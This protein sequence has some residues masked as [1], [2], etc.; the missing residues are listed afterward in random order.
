MTTPP[1]A[2]FRVAVLDALAKRVGK[3]LADARADCTPLF[4]AARA[5]GVKQ[6]EVALP[7]GEV[8]GTVSIA[9]SEDTIKVHEQA[10]LDWV[11]DNVPTEVETVV[12]PAALSRP[13][14]VAYV[15]RFYPDLAVKQVRQ[16]YRAKV[17]GRLNADGELLVEETGEVVKLADVTKGEPSGAFRLTFERAKN[18]KPAGRDL[19]AEAWASGE[20][21]IA[22]MLRPA[23]EGGDEQ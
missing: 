7:S 10:L 14:V 22:D 3:A 6:I 18:G 2:A 15:R 19:I 13:D 1:E 20:L 11:T 23:L 9:G 4:A 12:S 16:V 21:S 5:A 8:V 17:L